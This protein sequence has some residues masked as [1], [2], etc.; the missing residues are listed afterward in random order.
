MSQWMTEVMALIQSRLDADILAGE[1][2]KEY[3]VRAVIVCTALPIHLRRSFSFA[4]C[5]CPGPVHTLR[6]FEV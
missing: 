1:I 2:P 4:G 5:W 3:E 6:I